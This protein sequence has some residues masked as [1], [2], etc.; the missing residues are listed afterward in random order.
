MTFLWILLGVAV[1]AALLPLVVLYRNW[2]H[3]SDEEENP[4]DAF[5]EAFCQKSDR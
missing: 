4:A 5:E 2:C 3:E 1:G